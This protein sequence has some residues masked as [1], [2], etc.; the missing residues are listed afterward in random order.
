ML[1]I[2]CDPAFA[3]SLDYEREPIRQRL[4]GF[5]GF[6]AV[7]AV[8]ILQFPLR[9]EDRNAQPAP[10]ADP[11]RAEKLAGRIGDTDDPLNASLLRLGL[12]IIA[13]S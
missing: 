8:R 9:R 2:R 10:A 13:R 6:P 7:G 11:E 1:F 5:L 12:S 4:N 3:L